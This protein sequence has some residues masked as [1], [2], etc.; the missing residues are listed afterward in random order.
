MADEDEVG[1]V[2]ARRRGLTSAVT[3][4]ILG[5]PIKDTNTLD[6]YYPIEFRGV[7]VQGRVDDQ[8]SGRIW[9]IPESRILAHGDTGETIRNGESVHWYQVREDATAIEERYFRIP[10][11]TALRRGMDGER[12]V[13][14]SGTFGARLGRRVVG[15]PGGEVIGGDGNGD[16]GSGPGIQE[17]R[18]RV[19]GWH[20]AGS[21]M[22]SLAAQVCRSLESTGAGSCTR[23]LTEDPAEFI[24][25]G[26]PPIDDTDIDF[27]D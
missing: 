9:H 22:N 12:T 23:T 1:R 14:S 25:P 7:R 2:E 10:V 16:G 15:R 8:G 21:G 26:T 19:R 6:G 4:E 13:A 3:I 17:I 18:R 11:T 24:N 20:G 5:V 27:Y